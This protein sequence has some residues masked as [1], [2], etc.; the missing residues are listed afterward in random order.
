MLPRHFLLL[1]RDQYWKRCEL[2]L[3]R[4]HFLSR[5]M[6]VSGQAWEWQ[7]R[8]VLAKL[9]WWFFTRADASEYTG[10]QEFLPK[11]LGAP[12]KK[13][14]V[15][16][17]VHKFC[18]VS[19]EKKWN[20]MFGIAE[21][22]TFEPQKKWWNWKQSTGFGISARLWYPRLVLI[23][24]PKCQEMWDFNLSNISKKA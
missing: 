1:E 9:W 13:G 6:S 14:S 15:N 21:Q 2:A 22:N 10:V 16:D 3:I 18:R 8:R 11:I 17:Y 12:K 7:R 23:F 19:V 5:A 20:N 24:Y 4:G